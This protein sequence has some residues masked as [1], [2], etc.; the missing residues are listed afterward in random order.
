[1]VR[2]GVSINLYHTNVILCPNKKGQCPKEQLS[3]SKVPGL[4]KRRQSSAG[5]SLRAKYPDP[6]HLSSLKE[7]GAQPKWPLGSSGLRNRERPGPTD[8]NPGRQPLLW[9]QRN[10][11]RGDVHCLPQSLVGGLGEG[12]G[13][14]Q[15]TAPSLF[16]G[17]PAK[18]K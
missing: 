15:D 9:G 5:S 4:G 8:S 6:L 7:P 2:R 12:A 17:V 1:M 18:E 11:D 14:V 3:P 16:S 10:R 13:A